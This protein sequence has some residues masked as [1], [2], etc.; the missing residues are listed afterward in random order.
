MNM[1]C[2]SKQAYYKQ[3]E[4]IL[5]VLEKVTKE[6]LITAGQKLRNMI[7]EETGASPGPTACTY[8]AGRSP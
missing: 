6:E 3:V 4:T 8:K 7:L 1:P 5:D 2:L